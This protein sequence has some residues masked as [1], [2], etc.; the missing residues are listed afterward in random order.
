MPKRI[1]FDNEKYLAEQSAAILER[2]TKFEN[3]LGVNLTTDANFV[4]KQLF[5]S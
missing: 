4:S 3:K 1:G 5:M 2:V